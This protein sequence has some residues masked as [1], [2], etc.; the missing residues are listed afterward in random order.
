MK[1]A[2]SRAF[3]PA[4]I[5]LLVALLLVGISFQ[6]TV[7]NYLTEQ[8]QQGLSHDSQTLA[9]VAA[10]YAATTSVF[11][12]DFLTNL[13]VATQVSGSDAI[14]CDARG[15]LLICSDSP[16]GC[17]HQGLVLQNRDYLQQII[18]DGTVTSAGAIPELYSE[19]RYV[20]ATAIRSRFD[21]T[22]LGFV[23]VSTPQ[24][25]VVSVLKE[26]FCKLVQP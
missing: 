3:F 11:D 12:R 18:N 1:T 20:A 23:L 6:M 9:D 13:T 24:T 8:V 7:R 15:R 19:P 5:I 16:L 14:I 21:N 17:Q 2:F 22:I 25:Q 26:I 10:A 4:A